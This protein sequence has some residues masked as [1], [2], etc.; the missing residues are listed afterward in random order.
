MHFQWHRCVCCEPEGDN[1]VRRGGAA[2]TF[3]TLRGQDRGSDAIVELW[4][5]LTDVLRHHMPTWR[6]LW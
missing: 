3:K 5:A 4:H 6:W 1:Q 2:L